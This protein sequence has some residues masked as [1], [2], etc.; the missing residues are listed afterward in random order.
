MDN[1]MQSHTCP[2]CGRHMKS[3]EGV[4]QWHTH[5][6]KWCCPLHGLSAGESGDDCA[7]VQEETPQTTTTPLGPPAEEAQHP[8][9]AEP[10]TI[11][12]RVQRLEEIVATLALAAM[13]E[14]NRRSSRPSSASHCDSAHRSN[15]GRSRTPPRNL[16]A[17]HPIGLA[18]RPS[19]ICGMRL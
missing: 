5:M 10:L 11:F 19:K 3:A 16:L 13:N 1:I 4:R 17:R 6:G 14:E 2:R 9:S 15:H 12:G 18:V 7:C 8:E